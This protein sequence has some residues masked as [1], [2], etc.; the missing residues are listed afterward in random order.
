MIG[1]KVSVIIPTYNRSKYLKR[2]IQSVLEQSHNDIE[3]I[4]IDDASTDDTEK[5]VQS[6][7]DS[8]IIY[9][10]NDERKGANFCRNAGLKIAS[11]NYIAFLDDD[12]YYCDK[13]KL[14][15]QIGLF[16]KNKKL[17]FVGSAYYDELIKKERQPNVIGKVDKKLLI[18]FSDIETSTIMIK[19]E[20]IEKIGFLDEQFSSEQNH[21]F[22]YR[23]SKLYEF[24]Y[25]PEVAVIKGLSSSQIST[26]I[27]NKIIGYILF[28]KKHFHDFKEEGF[29][30]FTYAMLKFFFGLFM[31]LFIGIFLKKFLLIPKIYESMKKLKIRA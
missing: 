10:R 30:F 21:D 20:V 26:N 3:I 17:G 18:S 22:F 9:M 19:R 27:K 29:R 15:K 25:L 5:I 7:N 4:V 2:A 13:D 24:D 31:F 1:E 11:G 12:D 16:R 28:H 8:R 6:F 23:I 14:R